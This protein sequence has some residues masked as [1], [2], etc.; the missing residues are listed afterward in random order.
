[1]L[2]I[3]HEGEIIAIIVPAEFEKE[4]IEFFTP[5][6]FSQQLAYMSRPKG[7][8]IPAHTHNVVHR[9][10]L[11]TLETL[12]IRKGKVKIDFF[13]RDQ[14]FLESREVKTGDVVLLA[15]GGHGFTML[16][17]TEIVEVKQGPYAGDRDKVRFGGAKGGGKVDSSL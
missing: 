13:T 7:Y 5:D 17:Q 15:S 4:G 14:E 16:E 1:M 2:K 8:V 10:V 9:Q 6:N 3:V 11:N 12:F